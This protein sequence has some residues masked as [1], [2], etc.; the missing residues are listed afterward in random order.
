MAHATDAIKRR[1]RPAGPIR[2]NGQ[3][4]EPRCPRQA[5]FAIMSKIEQSLA[6]P[7]RRNVHPLQLGAGSAVAV[8]GL[9]LAAGHL[10]LG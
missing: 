9:L 1:R 7:L 2:V 4:R 3:M 10:L 8:A 5:R 6:L